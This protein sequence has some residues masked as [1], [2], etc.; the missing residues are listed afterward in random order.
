MKDQPRISLAALMG[1]VAALA[2]TLGFGMPGV[3]SAASLGPEATRLVAI[4]FGV[5]TFNVQA[6]YWFALIPLVRWLR[7]KR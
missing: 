3:R 6:C 2:L 1:G 4:Q 7:C 5:L